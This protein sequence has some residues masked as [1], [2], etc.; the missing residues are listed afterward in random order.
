MKCISKI[1]L[2]KT[3]RVTCK[4]LPIFAS[5]EKYVRLFLLAVFLVFCF[6]VIVV[7]VVSGSLLEIINFTFSQK[8]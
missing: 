4:Y 3:L 6:V 1:T 5:S 8:H 7:V 2:K